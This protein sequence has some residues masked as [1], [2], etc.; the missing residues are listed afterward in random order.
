MSTSISPPIERHLGIDLHKHYL[1]I[2]GVNAKQEVVLP[3]R[4][5]ELGDWP[6]WAK[7][8]LTQRD[9]VVVEATT[10]AWDFYDVTSPLVQR[11][12]V[13]NAAKIALIAKTRTKTDNKD[14]MVLARL[15]AAG[16]IPQVW[17]PPVEVRE[18]RALIAHRRRVVGTRTTLKNRLQSVLHRHHLMLPSGNPFSDIHRAWWNTLPVSPTER[19][20]LRHD[21]ATIAQLDTQVAEIEDELRRLSCASPWAAP[22]TYLM[23]LPGVALITAMTVLSAIGDVTR[24]AHAK[25]L[26]GYSGL[27]AGVH[28]SGQTHHTGHI[29]KE[30][31]K[32][33]RTVLVEAMWRTVECSDYW[34]AE[35]ERLTRRMP[36]PKAIVALARKMLVVIWHVLTEQAA[37]QH[38]NADL[39]A[40]KFMVWS[41]KLTTAQRGGLTTRQFVRY[42]LM[43]LGLGQD[44]THV[45]RGGA[46]HLIAPSEEV[47]ALKPEL[48]A[49]A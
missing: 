19:L 30:G 27:G 3:P 47:L 18:L 29:T 14:V 13:A 49:I 24:F 12:I 7:T 9:R 45:V 23:Q 36:P 2:G 1:V 39:V 26:V 41:W 34:R 44:L 15:S 22:V 43:H 33:L 28:D 38:A 21:L 8:H 42:Q 31:R 6:K 48:H 25:E 37:D 32:E 11:V 46:R 4:R 16:L 35:F 5:I 20:H 17:V 40:F 10:N